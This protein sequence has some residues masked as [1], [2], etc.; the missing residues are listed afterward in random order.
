MPDVRTG[1]VCVSVFFDVCGSWFEVLGVDVE[2]IPLAQNFSV[3]EM[4]EKASDWAQAPCLHLPET[5]F[6]SP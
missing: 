2:P 5:V 6:F 3:V 4:C 1:C